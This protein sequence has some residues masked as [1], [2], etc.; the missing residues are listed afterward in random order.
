MTLLPD[1][2]TLFLLLY[3][4]IWTWYEDLYLVLFHLVM[5]SSVDITR[6]I[7]FL[8]EKGIVDFGGEGTWGNRIGRAGGRGGSIYVRRIIK[9]KQEKK[10]S[11]NLEKKNFKSQ[12]FPFYIIHSPKEYYINFKKMLIN[13]CFSWP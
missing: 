9:R 12:S 3:C 10:T 5:L 11:K 8:K 2:G 6:I 4:L 1:L 7:S 13:T